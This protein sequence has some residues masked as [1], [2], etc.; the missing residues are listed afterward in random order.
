VVV[1][2]LPSP[3]HVNRAVLVVLRTVTAHV[4]VAMLQCPVVWVCGTAGH[5]R[6]QG[7]ARST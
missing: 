5:R 3:A 2:V 4:C 7:D 1:A 6:G